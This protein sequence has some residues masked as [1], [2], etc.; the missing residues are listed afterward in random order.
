MA[1]T[2]FYSWQKDTPENIGFAF[3]EEALSITLTELHA[4]ITLDKARRELELDRDT[5]NTPGQ[6][7]IMD[8]IL[9]KIDCAAVLVPDLTFVGKRL[10]NTRL[11]PN[12]N[13]LIEY[14][15]AMK[16]LTHE[17]IVPVMNTHYG[18]PSDAT[19][20]FDMKHRRYPIQYQCGPNTNTQERGRVLKK[21]TGELKE[22][23]AAVLKTRPSP[24]SATP[25]MQGLT[26]ERF[27]SGN[28][29]IGVTYDPLLPDGSSNPVVLAAGPA[30]WFKAAPAFDPRRTWKITEIFEVVRSRIGPLIQPFH[31]NPAGYLRAQDGFGIY[32]INKNNPGMTTRVIFISRNGEILTTVSD[33]IGHVKWKGQS[34]IPDMT[35]IFAKCLKN[36][37]EFLISL[38]ISPPFKW[39]VGM[40]GTKD[41]PMVT[42]LFPGMRQLSSKCLEPALF[43]DG[44]YKPGDDPVVALHSFTEKLYDSC[45]LSPPPLVSKKAE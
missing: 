13:V 7:P 22:A 43:G 30:V 35:D 17:R 2:V 29:P 36:Y 6:P 23:I 9:R 38:G 34:I 28:Q 1:N 15:Y 27:R 32:A 40:Q 16:A 18:E 24:P 8:T 14:G 45:G 44:D 21:L 26:L 12:P 10:D 11:T 25:F 19:M 4:D 39:Q 42:E 20:P 5:Q 33:V 3:I 37:P 31:I 41:L